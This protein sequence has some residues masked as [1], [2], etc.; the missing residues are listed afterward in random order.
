M[1]NQVYSPSPS[2][3]QA[4]AFLLISKLVCHLPV[5]SVCIPLHIAIFV[6]YHAIQ[7]GIGSK[8]PPNE[9]HSPSP[10]AFHAAAFSLGLKSI[11]HQSVFITLP[12]VNFVV[13]SHANQ[14]GIGSKESSNRVRSPSLSTFHAFK[15]CLPP[16]RLLLADFTTVTHG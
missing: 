2:A 7:A 4:T 15:I 16:I 13:D 6:N 8:E 3:F 11:Y 12:I 9:V 14:T 5:H 10:R 1:P